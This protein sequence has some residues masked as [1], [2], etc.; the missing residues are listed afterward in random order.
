MPSISLKPLD[1]VRDID[2]YYDLNEACVPEVNSLPKERLAEL[3]GEAAYARAAW[4][5]DEPAGVMIAFS[6]DADYDS[7]NFLWFRE[8]LNDFL[9]M[10]RIMV[11]EAAR[12]MGVGKALYDDL[13][14]FAAGSW[15]C[16]TCEV[17][18][19]P[20][21]PGSMAFHEGLGFV[22]VGEQKTEGGKKSVV[23]LRKDV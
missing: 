19:H 11:T 6:Q 1:P 13:F 20:P 10:D 12:R 15:E 9:Y 14:R 21:N 16:V 4:K 17:N 7:L 18:S 23:L 22:S 8:R 2:W 3:I 5:G